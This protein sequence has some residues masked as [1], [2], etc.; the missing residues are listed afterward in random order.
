[1]NTSRLRIG[2]TRKP[3]RRVWMHEEE[4]TAIVLKAHACR[5]TQI[6]R[7]TWS[8]PIVNGQDLVAYYFH[9]MIGIYVT[10]H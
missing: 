6:S 4:S 3:G 7:G 1:M 2:L 5:N 10:E 8:V 9:S